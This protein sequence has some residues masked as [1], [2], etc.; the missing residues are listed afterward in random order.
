V[1]LLV[2]QQQRAVDIS[3]VYGGGGV[4]QWEKKCRLIGERWN[5]DGI[6]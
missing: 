3:V 1:K 4:I 6:G 2:I 5:V